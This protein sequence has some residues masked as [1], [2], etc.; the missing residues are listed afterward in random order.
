MVCVLT[1]S[2]FWIGENKLQLWRWSSFLFSF[3]TTDSRDSAI[4]CRRKHSKFFA[5]TTTFFEYLWAAGQV[6][7][8]WGILALQTDTDLPSTLLIRKIL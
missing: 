2:M 5:T 8:L 1:E 4:V 6:K 3:R 7:P